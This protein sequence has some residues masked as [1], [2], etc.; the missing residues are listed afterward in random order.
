MQTKP[1]NLLT[2]SSYNRPC[3]LVS[4]LGSSKPSTVVG[5]HSEQPPTKVGTHMERAGPDPAR[6]ARGGVSFPS[7]T[8]AW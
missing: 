2:G 6:E 1:L 8:P 7:K 4:Q 5:P 3:A